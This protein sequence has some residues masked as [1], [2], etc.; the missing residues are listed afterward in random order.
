MRPVRAKRCLGLQDAMRPRS[1]HHAP[2]LQPKRILRVE[3][4]S[5]GGILPSRFLD[6]NNIRIHQSHGLPGFPS[7]RGTVG[8]TEQILKKKHAKY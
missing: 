8:R 2:Q 5:R 4:M 1:K 6:N 7:Q 3:T